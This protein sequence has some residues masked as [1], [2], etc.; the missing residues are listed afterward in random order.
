MLI[1]DKRADY[2]DSMAYAYGIDN[3]RVFVRKSQ[4]IEITNANVTYTEHQL[5]RVV[6][7]STCRRNVTQ[8]ERLCESNNHTQLL[9]FCG[10]VYPFIETTFRPYEDKRDEH[11]ELIPIASVFNYG[12]PEIDTKSTYTRQKWEDLKLNE[13]IIV[14]MGRLLDSPYFVIG[15]HNGRYDIRVPLLRE[16]GFHNIMQ[17]D[18][19]YQ[20]I[21]MKVN[22]MSNVENN[23]VVVGNDDRIQQHGFDLTTS[24][25]NRPK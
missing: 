18:E 9:V 3:K 22:E 5:L 8:E 19:C 10:K 12:Y 25:R 24:F 21:E 7:W 23:M 13:N 11:F 20:Q 6:G 14:G 1:I 15:R 4:E 17:A 16:I 2:Y